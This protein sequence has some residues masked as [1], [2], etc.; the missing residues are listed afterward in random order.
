MYV[1]AECLYQLFMQE[2]TGID[3]KGVG[4]VLF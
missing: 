1:D 3:R 4:I 2:Y